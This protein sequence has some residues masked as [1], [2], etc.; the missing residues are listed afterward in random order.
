MESNVELFF[1]LVMVFKGKGCFLGCF[2]ENFLKCKKKKVNYISICLDE[3]FYFFVGL[4]RIF[5]L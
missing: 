2:V 5:C 1:L 4:E 3:S